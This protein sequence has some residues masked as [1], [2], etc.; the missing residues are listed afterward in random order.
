MQ[1]HRFNNHLLSFV[2]ELMHCLNLFV[3]SPLFLPFFNKYTHSLLSV[4]KPYKAKIT[5]VL[6][7]FFACFFFLLFFNAHLFI[8]RHSVHVKFTSSSFPIIYNI[9]S[10]LVPLHIIHFTKSICHFSPIFC[11]NF[12]DLFCC[13]LRTNILRIL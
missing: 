6:D 9:F 10:I 11:F 13:L 3:L 5:L 7:T 2:S 12:W 8:G 1:F 4:A